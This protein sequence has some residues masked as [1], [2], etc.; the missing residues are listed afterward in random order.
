MSRPIKTVVATAFVCQSTLNPALAAGEYPPYDGYLLAYFTGNSASQERISFAYSLDGRRF[1]KLNN[2]NP[3]INGDLTQSGGLRDPYITRG[4]D[5]NFYMTATDMRSSNGWGSNRG[6]VLM[7]SPDL[8]HWK[9]SNINFETQFP[10]MFPGVHAVWAPQVA[11]NPLTSQNMVYLTVGTNE[12]YK[13]YYAHA[14][15]DF[16]GLV[17]TP[18]Q[19][20]YAR[21]GVGY[22]DSDITEQDGKYHLL[23]KAETRPD[24]STAPLR[25]IK[26]AVSDHLTWGYLIPSKGHLQKTTEAVEGPQTYRLNDGSGYMVMYDK[27]MHDWNRGTFELVKTTD[28]KTFTL[29]QNADINSLSPRHGGVVSLTSDELHRVLDNDTRITVQDA[30]A[31]SP[32]TSTSAA[33]GTTV[34]AAPASDSGVSR[35][36]LGTLKAD[37]SWAS[38]IWALSGDGSVAVGDAYTDAN[39]VNMRA[40]AWSGTDLSVKQD[41]GTLRTDNTGAAKAYAISKDGSVIGGIAENADETLHA[42]LWSGT[43]WGT[44]TDLGTL[45]SDQSGTSGIYALSN[46]GVIAAGE[47]S[48]D[49]G[50]THAAIWSGRN[51]TTKT[52]LGTLRSDNSGMSWAYA[53]ASDGSV[54]GGYSA[55]DRN[56]DVYSHATLW[57]GANWATKTDLGTLRT[58]NRGTSVV[59]ALSAD[60]TV[61][62]GSSSTDSGYTH[63]ALWSGSR[64]SD[65]RDLGTLRSDNSGTSWVRALSADGRI[66]G[67][68]ASTV[69][70]FAHGVVWHGDGWQTK[71]DLGTLR[72]D[73]RGVSEV[74]ALSADGRIAAGYSETDSGDPHAVLWK[75][76]YPASA[77]V[78]QSAAQTSAVQSQTLTAAAQNP[79]SSQAAQSAAAATT[80]QAATATQ[81][82]QSPTAAATPAAQDPAAATTVTPTSTVQNAASST[83]QAAAQ[84]TNAI[85]ATPAAAPEAQTQI[86][87]VTNTRR[88]IGRLRY[89][90]FS[91]LEIQRQS[92]TYL[93]QNFV[94]PKGQIGWGAST[95]FVSDGR[96]ADTLS[97]LPL[98]YGLTDTLTVGG[99]LS[100]APY[101][102]L[103]SPAFN[104]NRNAFGAGVFLNW[105]Q[106]YAG[107]EVFVRSTFAFSRYHADVRRTQMSGTEA[108]VGGS[109]I[110]GLAGAIEVG[111]DLPL[112]SDLVVGWHGGVRT[113]RVTRQGYAEANVSFPVQYGDVVYRSTL[114]YLGADITV[115]LIPNVQWIS[116]VEVEQAV[117][118]PTMTFTAHADYI[119]DFRYGA[120]LT[121][122][123]GEAK[124]GLRFRLG[125]NLTM[126]ATTSVRTTALGTTAIGGMLAFGGQL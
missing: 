7:Q 87:D 71:T 99:T 108:G 3:V 67:G 8:L 57:S 97:S 24:G 78:S 117:R 4:Q 91:A 51:W 121:R 10:G 80:N 98:G 75:I 68:T 37:N 31:S 101:R 122:T 103:P 92:L 47:S 42:V 36:D 100:Y 83:A 22:I 18:R 55:T 114:A 79:G 66:A 65:K 56:V 93:Q 1:N 23:M 104:D 124:T 70:G 17:E 76:T 6:I 45:T 125:D 74:Q 46:D 50:T 41:L 115:P 81:T 14:N 16:T 86:V 112:F 77:S 111:Q 34:F 94:V 118:K 85:P 123:R 106:P 20:F 43:S 25:V 49:S 35:K 69:T 90:T 39:G 13:P 95:G 58:D 60:G 53:L 82:A 48:V 33:S 40:A 52:D 32:S 21:D 9:S 63:A 59:R 72:T 84:A 120:D 102:V 11:Y 105:H 27:Y 107:G 12:P 116:G 126:S 109:Q 2:G 64:W 26:H 113:S 89:E 19:L 96:N 30:A 15:R 38:E 44:K 88:T 29:V 28:F 62:A 110:T 61:A 5:G 119:G 54:V 73:G